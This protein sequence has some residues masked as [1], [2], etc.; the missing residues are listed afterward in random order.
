MTL[1]STRRTWAIVCTVDAPVWLIGLHARY[2]RSLGA[3]QIFYFI[4]NPAKYT[5]S[6]LSH[7]N[8]M[9]SLI[10]CNDAYWAQFKARPTKLARRQICN[11]EYIRTNLTLDWY[12]HID[13]DEFL[14]LTEDIQQYIEGLPTE[15]SEV[16][17]KNVERV[18]SGELSRWAEGYLRLQTISHGLLRNEYGTAAVFFGMGL[19]N[20]FHGK[21]FVSNRPDIAQNIH[22]AVHKNPNRE[23]VRHE[24]STDKAT[25]IHFPCITESH[26][27]NRFAPDLLGITKERTEFIHERRFRMFLRQ[28]AMRIGVK[29][30][31]SDGFKLLHCCENS[32]A[33][34]RI[35]AGIYQEMPH[36][37]VI[38][39]RE[40]ASET[41]ELNYDF[42]DQTIMA[43]QK[44][45]I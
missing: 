3:N 32:T 14:H 37:F 44:L 35:D 34:R 5:H 18:L 22:G 6:D 28:L 16:R 31:L 20:Y 2:H 4:D 40:V 19:S 42:A 7:L 13:I 26:F 9:A 29:Q 36:S 1:A 17:V 15:I 11:I 27:V 23:I 12:L 45:E 30:A 21:S 33:E 41:L 43:H 39:L 24:I 38:R 10:V 25:I 8:G